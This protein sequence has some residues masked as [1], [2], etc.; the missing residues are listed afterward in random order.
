[1]IPADYAVLI[2][3]LK[4]VT[5]EKAHVWQKTSDKDKF[6]LESRGNTVIIR[7]YTYYKDEYDVDVPVVSLQI[8][9]SK[10]EIIDGL[11]VEGTEPEYEQLDDL[12]VSARRNALGIKE[13]ISSIVEG[14]DDLLLP[15]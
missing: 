1:M 10:G 7:S 5:K 13:T 11:Y 2:D 12:Y 8:M 6:S 4:E 3:K 15:F 14:L 9:N